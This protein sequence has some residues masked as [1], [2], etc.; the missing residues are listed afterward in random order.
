MGV[1]WLWV[2]LSVV[3]RGIIGRSP[4]LIGIAVLGGS[5]GLVGGSVVTSTAYESVESPVRGCLNSFANISTGLCDVC[6]SRIL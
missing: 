4:V 1:Y 5:V 3:W 2:K 6:Q